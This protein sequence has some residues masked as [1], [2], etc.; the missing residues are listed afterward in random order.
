[1]DGHVH[2]QFEGQASLFSEA[3][4]PEWDALIQEGHPCF[5][6]SVFSMIVFEGSSWTQLRKPAFMFGDATPDTENQLL[7]EK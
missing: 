7:E 6:R 2:F 1:M 3:S 4:A 5:L